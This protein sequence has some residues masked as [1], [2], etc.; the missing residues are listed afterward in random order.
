MLFIS[1][2][3]TNTLTLFDVNTNRIID[4][5]KVGIEPN[6]ILILN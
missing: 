6:G 5:I 4:N 3:S 2:I 1:N